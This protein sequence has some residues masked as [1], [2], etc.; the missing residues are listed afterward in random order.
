MENPSES[1]RESI[2]ST[3]ELPFETDT[4]YFRNPRKT[5]FRRE[6]VMSTRT[7][8]HE[9]KLQKS[10][11]FILAVLAIGILLNAFKPIWSARDAQALKKGDKYN[12]IYVKMSL[13]GGVDVK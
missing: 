9:I 8:S 10:V 3:K 5:P 6:E 4:V 2:F 1:C 11:I 7:I 12:P 13:S